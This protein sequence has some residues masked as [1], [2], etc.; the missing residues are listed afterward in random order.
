MK[1]IRTSF[2]FRFSNILLQKDRCSHKRVCIMYGKYSTVYC[3][4]YM[5]CGTITH[6]SIYFCLPPEYLKEVLGGKFNGYLSSKQ[7]FI[8]IKLTLSD[9]CLRLS[10]E[11]NVVAKIPM[12]YSF[13]IIFFSIR[14]SVD[15][16][17]V[18]W[19]AVVRSDCLSVNVRSVANL[20]GRKPL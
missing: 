20:A 6:T 3:V 12:N 15:G 17:S 7:C 8:D 11:K 18:G 5:Q 2:Y 14:R 9:P 16:R 19:L 4:R 13:C 1:Q 10:I